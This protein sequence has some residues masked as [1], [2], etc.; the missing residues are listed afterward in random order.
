MTKQGIPAKLSLEESPHCCN[1]I[2]KSYGTVTTNTYVTNQ[3]C[4]SL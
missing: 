2:T 3:V 1:E 4:V